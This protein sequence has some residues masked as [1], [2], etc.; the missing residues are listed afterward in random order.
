MPAAPS[1]PIGYQ[2][3][4]LG[5][6]RRVGPRQF[7]WP[8]QF[9]GDLD[10]VIITETWKVA[11]GLYRPAELKAPH[12]LWNQAYL[13]KETKPESNGLGA[14]KWQRIYAS[15]PATQVTY[16]PRRYV[17]KPD[18]VNTA[19]PY[20]AQVIPYDSSGGGALIGPAVTYTPYA[21]VGRGFV[22]VPGGIYTDGDGKYYA[23]YKAAGAQAFGYATAGTFTITWGANTTAA[24]AYNASNATIAAAINGL[25]SVSGAGITVGVANSLVNTAGGA[26]LVIFLTA[27]TTTTPFT[28]DATSLT[29]TT[30]QHPTT[31]VINGLQQYIDLPSHHT[32]TAHGLD[33]ALDLAVARASVEVIVYPT[34]KW[35]SIGTD[36]LW[37]PNRST[38]P[39]RVATYGFVPTPAASA[40]Y[41]AGTRFTRQ[42]LTETFYLPGVTGGINT[43]AD[44]TVAAGLQN[45]DAFLEA[46]LTPLTGFQTY[47][48]EGPSPWLDFP[49][50]VVRTMA[51]HFTDLV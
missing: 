22:A 16:P 8:F 10:T 6:P 37:I 36:T 43:P 50:H 35:G 27:G 20:S 44:I 31:S 2:D 17:T 25:A 45:P 46:L 7:E 18:F 28:M 26:N 11:E 1:I 39:D 4:Y 5:I 33:T 32:V 21:S 15:I 13:M 29:V 38:L 3:G 49:I 12:P 47:E 51:L 9:N 24:L 34:G 48:V 30:S 14:V 23:N 40:S 41:V 42:R 19:G